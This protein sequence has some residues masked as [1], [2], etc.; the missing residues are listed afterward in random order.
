M[1][2][3]R[4][5]G[6][7]LLS[8]HSG[9]HHR[10]NVAGIRIRVDVER[11]TD[12]DICAETHVSFQIVA[13]SVL[14]EVVDDQHTDK[15]DDSLE[16]LEVQRHVLSDDPTEN[17]HEGSDEE[18]DLHRASNGNSDGQ[19]HLVLP[20]NDNSRDVLSGVANDGNE[21]ETD[22]SLA[23][24]SLGDN[25]VDAVN[26]VLGTDGDQ[27]G[28]NEKADGG[29][30]GSEKLGLLFLLVF[31]HFGIE[32]ASV[33][34]QLEV[35]VEAVENEENDGG[36]TREDQDVVVGRF[37]ALCE[38]SVESGGNDERGGSNGHQRGHG[39]CNGGVEGALLAADT[40]R[41]E[42]AS[43][44]EQ[45]VGEDGTQHAGLDDSDL[46]FAEGNDRDLQALA[47]ENW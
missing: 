2:N 42:A 27:D 8:R 34:L 3:R 37:L 31:S 12:D 43:E 1:Q 16:A 33:R 44:D 5:S 35:E 6:V 38:R 21:D 41:D 26:Q 39:R 40:R 32:E 28:D 7:C 23:D 19:I 25:G 9:G 46:A 13:L 29:S 4:A 47:M 45:N 20:S 10:A 18:S 36:S 15:E 17:D 14:D 11:N 22:E 24:T 30:D